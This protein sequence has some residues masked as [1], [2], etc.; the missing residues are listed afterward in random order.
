MLAWLRTVVA[1]DA[2]IWL[3]VRFDVSSEKS[4][5]WMSDWLELTFSYATFSE[6]TVLS[7]VYF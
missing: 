4:A 2:R 1:A 7:T 5:S 6:F 3:R